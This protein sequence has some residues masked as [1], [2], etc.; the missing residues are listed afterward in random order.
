VEGAWINIEM[1]SDEQ[2]MRSALE[3]AALAETAGE[4]PIGAVIVCDGKII[5][6]GFNRNLLDHDP[7]AHAEMVALRE[8]ARAM[9]NHR[10]SGCEMFV[11]MEPC[12]MCAG[13]LVHSRIARLVYGASDP[14]AGAVSSVL[15]V[16]NHPKL[17]HQM[18]VTSGVLAAECSEVVQAFF[19]KKRSSASRL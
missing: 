13:A 7:S 12:A 17:N 14:K 6:R 8:A 3:Q 18:N 10:L 4:V 2:F 5:S 11:T 16:L 19:R 15:H 9:Q 1:N